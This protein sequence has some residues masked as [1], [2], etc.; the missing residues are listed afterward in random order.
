MGITQTVED[1]TDALDRRDLDT[2]RA[3]F[4]HAIQGRPETAVDILVRLLAATVTIPAGTVV[5]GFGIDVWANPHRW[6]YAWR[7]GGV[8]CRW[9]GSNYESMTAARSAAAGHAAEHPTPPSVVQY[10]SDSYA[11]ALDRLARSE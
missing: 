9:T 2:A 7:C 6:D 5:Y 4:D 10:G 1:I 8:K 3:A 11:D